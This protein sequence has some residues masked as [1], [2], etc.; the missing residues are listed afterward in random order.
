MRRLPGRRVVIA[1]AVAGVLVLIAARVVVVAHRHASNP[2]RPAARPAAV[3]GTDR[4]ESV[5]G[6]AG[7]TGAASLTAPHGTLAAVWC[8]SV[9]IRLS[10]SAALPIVAHGVLYATGQHDPRALGVDLSTGRT[11]SAVHGEGN[12]GGVERCASDRRGL[13]RGLRCRRGHGRA[14]LDHAGRTP[15]GLRSGRADRGREPGVRAG[16]R[17]RRRS[18][19]AVGPGSGVRS[20]PGLPRPR[21]RAR[22]VPAAGGGR[23][24]GHRRRRHV[25][26]GPPGQAPRPGPWSWRPWLRP[27]DWWTSTAE[28]W[29]RSGSGIFPGRS[30]DWRPVAGAWWARCTRP[31][32]PRPGPPGTQPTGGWRG[33]MA[34]RTRVPSSRWSS[35]VRCSSPRWA[36]RTRAGPVPRRG[37]CPPGR[38]DGVAPTSARSGCPAGS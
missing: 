3:A 25:A 10:P 35:T 38:P 37:I 28:R 15:V 27:A 20:A 36:D 14:A 32:P 11:R 23:R 12:A 4:V 24:S 31:G 30:I 29:P 34:C 17:R 33:P 13:R 19:L 22:A 9:D 2:C 7:A 5:L 16:R 8:A 6:D 26:S 1:L 21:R 18:V